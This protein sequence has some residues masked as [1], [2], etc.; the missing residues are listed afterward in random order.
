VGKTATVDRDLYRLG[1]P[2][3]SGCSGPVRMRRR[4]TRRGLTGPADG[5]GNGMIAG[6]KRKGGRWPIFVG[7]ALL[8]ILVIFGAGF[9][10]SR[11][12]ASKVADQV[13]KAEGFV[14]DT[15][16]PA[17]G[18]AD[19]SQPLS[20]S[21]SASLDQKFS[22][23]VLAGGTVVRV[24]V[25]ATDGKLIYSTDGSDQIGAGKVGD[26]DGIRAAAAGA[27]T[28]LVDDDRVS[29][30]GGASQSVH[31]LQAYVPLSSGTGGRPLGVVEVDQRMRPIEDAAKQPWRTVQLVAVFVAF[32]F[33][34]LGL[35]SFARATAA[36]Q[37]ASRSGFAT[38][39]A[40]SSAQAVTDAKAADKEAQI[41]LALEDQ[42]ETLRTQLKRQEEESTNAAREFAA[43]LQE[44]SRRS[45]EPP[46]GA[47]P[48]DEVIRAADERIH[49]AELRAEEAERRGSVAA[50]R[51]D[52]AE[53]RLAQ[54]EAE[55][56]KAASAAKETSPT[57][58]TAAAADDGEGASKARREHEDL[59][60]EHEKLRGELEAERARHEGA[61]G[62]QEAMAT[63]IGELERQSSETVARTDVQ[64]QRAESAEAKV[65]ELQAQIDAVRKET[66][67]HRNRAD[68]T[69]AVR[70]ELET[71]MAQIT[72]R[73]QEAEQRAAQF[74]EKVR[75]AAE[76][77]R[78]E[79]DKVLEAQRAGDVVRQELVT[80]SSERDAIA[81]ER[82]ALRAQLSGHHEEPQPVTEHAA[83]L[84][85]RE[86]ELA[87]LKMQIAE[88]ASRSAAALEIAESRT[89]ETR[90]AWETKVVELEAEL[91]AHQEAVRALESRAEAAERRAE[92]AEASLT[93][94]SA[95]D[96]GAGKTADHDVAA[97]IA[98]L[99]R[100]RDQYADELEQMQLRLR[101][102]YADAEDAR[103]Q[104]QVGAPQVPAAEGDDE[105]QRLRGELA[106]AMD[107][108]QRAENQA[109]MLQADLAE[110][111]VGPNNDAIAE[112]ADEPAAVPTNQVDKSLRFRLARSAAKKKGIGGE[113]EGDDDNMWA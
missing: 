9:M 12:L 58:P 8:C 75:E 81:N 53:A 55:L 28:N 100:Q 37:L 59:K 83:L 111:G 108:A 109:S 61:R 17:V 15:V 27:T 50:S 65:A 103:A 6:S 33:L 52:V 16:S 89:E 4:N 48:P 105:V 80:V 41:R 68:A 57:S 49:A 98:D 92:Q 104:L 101:R 3:H 31:M 42:L 36:K 87:S 23:G 1:V 84:E 10:Q 46:R 30:D 99:E 69:E 63:R 43:Q 22:K 106:R 56:A 14:G 72:S 54:L 82:D 34:E 25:F 113:D 76:V 107:R 20:A 71:K 88:G 24:R 102:A 32:L 96:A 85:Q 13:G 73:A 110:A 95:E 70:M 77:A 112:R 91:K 19:L 93:E 2:P 5:S 44:A 40:Q 51:V 86:G 62:E 45:G 29:T 7:L 11:T 38:A 39:A 97:R 26:D 21:L 74:E 47:A 64:T 18:S 35:V 67:E 94:R 60:A 90:M 79:N 66:A 78:E